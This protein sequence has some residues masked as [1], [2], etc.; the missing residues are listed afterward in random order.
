MKIMGFSHEGTGTG[1]VGGWVLLLGTGDGGGGVGVAIIPI[2]KEYEN[3]GKSSKWVLA[4]KEQVLL[5]P[6]HFENPGNHWSS[7]HHIGSHTDQPTSYLTNYIPQPQ[8][9]VGL[10]RFS[11][12]LQRPSGQRKQTH[13]Y[14]GKHNFHRSL[15]STAVHGRPLIHRNP[16][17]HLDFIG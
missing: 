15:I 1:R 7:I 3:N 16:I 13:M 8:A 14:E 17:N 5:M 4:T 10:N 9:V 11:V 2:I 12:G 6:L